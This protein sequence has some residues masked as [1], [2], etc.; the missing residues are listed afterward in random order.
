MTNIT[1]AS[2]GSLDYISSIGCSDQTTVFIQQGH[3]NLKNTRTAPLNNGTLVTYSAAKGFCAWDTSS[4]TDP[5]LPIKS[6]QLS[7]C[8][9][10]AQQFP[11]IGSKASVFTKGNCNAAGTSTTAVNTPLRGLTVQSGPWGTLDYYS[12]K[13]FKGL[14]WAALPGACVGRFRPCPTARQCIANMR[15]DRLT[16]SL[17]AVCCSP[18]SAP[19]QAVCKSPAFMTNF[20]FQSYVQVDFVDSIGCSDG[21]SIAVNQGNHFIGDPFPGGVV[22]RALQ[23]FTSTAG[24]CG[25]SNSTSDQALLVSVS[26]TTCATS[27]TLQTTS[28]AG[29]AKFGKV[30]FT[31]LSCVTAKNPLGQ[32]AGISVGAASG[33]PG[34]YSATGFSAICAVAPG[35]SAP[36]SVPLCSAA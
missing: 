16:L 28:T 15:S 19:T 21:T 8:D 25:W 4:E 22:G 1:I 14:C 18:G 33:G 20:T 23:S 36:G 34:H 32:L 30:P 12:V 7:D 13:S 27:T 9:T 29:T 11:L 26:L 35:L 24:F 17:R 10:P 6:L 5:K 2:S 31:G 3:L